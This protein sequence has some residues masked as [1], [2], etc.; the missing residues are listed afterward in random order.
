MQ[1]AEQPRRKDVN[2]MRTST[3]VYTDSVSEFRNKTLALFQSHISLGGR[4]AEGVV[5]YN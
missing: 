5:K 1:M 2:L 3:A 4:E